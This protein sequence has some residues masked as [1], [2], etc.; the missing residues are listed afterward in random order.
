MRRRKL[1][2]SATRPEPARLPVRLYGIVLI[3]GYP[4][5]I[6]ARARWAIAAELNRT[7]EARARARMTGRM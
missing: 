3:A 7:G 1:C 6:V 4:L 2:A 5:Q